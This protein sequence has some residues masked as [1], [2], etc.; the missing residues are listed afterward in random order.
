MTPV[1]IDAGV[2]YQV[3]AMGYFSC[4]LT[5]AGVLK[6]WGLNISVAPQATNTTPQ[7][8]DTAAAYVSV[9]VGRGLCAQTA[10]GPRKCAGLNLDGDLGDGTRTSRPKLS[11]V[12]DDN[13]YRSIQMG[14]HHTC[15]IG[16]DSAVY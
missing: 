16:V 15:A 4:C 5:T 9:S 11:F 2:S 13:R 10:D 1:D 14:S 7:V 6:C 3:L 8:M 12:Q